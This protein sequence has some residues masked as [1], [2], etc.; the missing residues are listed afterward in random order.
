M[1]TVTR[2]MLVVAAFA[3]VL[4]AACQSPSST[5]STG[6]SELSGT[7]TSASGAEAGVWVIAETTSLPTKFSKIVVTDDRGRYLI[8][9][10][11]KGN[12]S[13]WVRGYGLVDSPKVSA[14]PGAALDLRAVI[15]PNAAAAAE[16][17]PSIY[18]YSML[19]IPDKKEFPGTGVS[20]S[21]NG[22]QPA[23]LTQYH[24]LN[25]IKTNGCLSCHGLGTKGTRTVPK[26]FAHF[27]TSTEAWA[28]RVASGQA[29]N[30]MITALDRIGTLRALGQ[31][32]D[33]T[34]RVAAGE[35]PFDKPQ[36]PQGVERNVVL[37]LWDW[38]RNTAYL[39]DLIGTDRRKPT[40]NANGKFYGSAEFSTDWV[41]ILDP[42]TNTSSEVFHPVRDPKTPSHITDPM[43]PSPYWGDKPIWDARTS[44][45]NPM[46]DGQGRVWFTARVRPFDNPAFCRKGSNHPSAK[47][48][49]MERS[50][51]HTSMYEPK[52]GKFSLISTCFPTHHLSFG[53]D[54][55]N[56]LWFSSG[57]GG[58]NVLGWVNSALYDKTSDEELAQ[59]WTPFIVDA[60]GNGKRDAWVEPN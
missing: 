17:Y 15:A 40:I 51:R 26:D 53:E 36:R 19:K 44:N 25:Q 48:F 54:A 8:P 28:R 60:N 59:G 52:S 1:R 57:S 18:W 33:W 35:L 42:Q 47:V 20:G 45:H 55:S 30:N 29:M 23:M 12:Y 58:N 7:V 37:T 49:P 50:T 6:G 46:M 21:G 31:F 13:V 27:P 38:S 4:I 10:L 22:I 32:A 3:A 16:Y 39:H 11:P 2:W 9:D 5:P 56:T 43:S 24:W 41:P 14:T 34:D